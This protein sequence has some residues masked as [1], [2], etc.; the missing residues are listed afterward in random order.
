[1][2]PVERYVRNLGRALTG[3]PS[4]AAWGWK[5]S[6][7]DAAALGRRTIG[8][9]QST[10]GVSTLAMADNAT[11][12]A[13]ASKAL[14]DSR[15]ASAG[16]QAFCAEVIGTG[17]RPHS[18]H[19][20]KDIRRKI[21][22]EFGLWAPQASAARKIGFGGK[23]ESLNDFWNLQALMCRNVVRA[24]EGF[25]RLRPRLRADLS[26]TGLRVPLQIDLLEPEQLALWRMSGI[27]QAPN[28]IVRASIEFNEIH[29][30]VAYHFYRD[31][32]GDTTLWPNAFEVV[33]VPAENVIHVMEFIAGNQIRGITPLAP[34]LIA[35]AD[36]DDFD[37]AERLRQ[38]L[39]AYFFSWRESLTPDDP[40]VTA[41]E[42]VGNDDAPPGAAYVDAQPGTMT[43]L[44][45]NAGE[46]FGF[47]AHPGV[48]NTYEAFMRVQQKTIATALRVSYDMMTG[49]MNEVN[50]SSAR[51]RLIALRRIW[52]QFQHQVIVQQFCRPVWRAWLDS[53]ALAG[54]ISQS[55]Y[56][57]RPEEYL[58]VEW[59]AQPWE[60]VDP[61]A[62]V[63]AVRMEIE[64]CL[65]SREAIVASRGRDVE[66]V[67]AEIKRDHDREARLGIVPVYGNSRVTE[68]VPPGDNE[69]LSGTD[70]GAKTTQRAGDKV[71]A[72]EGSRLIVAGLTGE[73]RKEEI[74]Q[75]IGSKPALI[76]MA[77]AG[78]YFADPSKYDVEPVSGIA[79]IDIFGALSNSKWS[80]GG[81]TYG[82]LQDQLKMA[83]SDGRVRGVIL[84]INSPGGETDNSFETADVVTSLRAVKPVFAVAATTA[85]SAAYMLASQADEVYC[86]PVSGSVGSIG[87]WCA[88]LDHSEMLKLAGISVTL[89]SAG[90]GKTDGNPYE[91]L[92]DSARQT[93]QKEIDRLYGA[94][95]GIVSR[96]RN[97]DASRIIKMGAQLVEGASNAIAVRLAT[98]SGDY[99][100]AFNDMYAGIL[101]GK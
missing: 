11:L 27:Q 8:M 59:L 76:H 37:D 75:R 55:D 15:M 64:S 100:T 36:L 26:P 18:R 72:G 13:R 80:W 78:G 12:T 20:D 85:Y 74:A 61:K 9:A 63:T 97:I 6:G 51:V 19:S 89:I 32:P 66:E 49:D 29:E 44:D 34:V 35:L 50:Y 46:K 92:S 21:E 2:N 90:A 22:Q 58:N 33:R 94:F 69:D 45:A 48:V 82:E 62:D 86:A 88:H 17:I 71:S 43:M 40:Q 1:M 70:G 41:L 38:K 67:D 91:P 93:T 84:N 81:T 14:Q 101:R 5:T 10:R 73:G 96:G 77:S 25:A 52:K 79:T 54:I 95:V 3:K 16:V 87:V 28:T 24:G 98:R 47:Y 57:R 23:P 83:A 30:R 39:G 42:N 56:L 60:W 68:N 4:A 31:H 99:G 7:Y 65:V 53:A